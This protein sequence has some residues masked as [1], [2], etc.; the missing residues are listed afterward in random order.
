M[1]KKTL[2]PFIDVLF[3]LLCV[4]ISISSLLKHAQKES[5][6][7]I[8]A[9]VLYQVIMDW[10]GTSKTDMDLWSKD[11]QGHIVGFNNREGGEGSLFSL[12]HDDLGSK[13]DQ[14]KDKNVVA[15]N[16]EIISIRGA[17]EGEY[18]ANG[19]AYAKNQEEG[20]LKV[21]CKLVKIKP[22]KEIIKVEREFKAHGDEVTFFRFK[23]DKEG[24]VIDTN[25]LP[26]K[27]VTLN[28]GEEVVP[29]LE[30]FEQK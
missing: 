30:Q 9:N 15:V 10:E 8:S 21:T 22:F 1:N 18:V 3:I 14:T 2:I 27:F 28:K 20:T 4:F 7:S 24:V 23:F 13:N 19:H 26:Q 12:A 17:I 5:E 16:Q 29:S 6:A 25:E 11:P